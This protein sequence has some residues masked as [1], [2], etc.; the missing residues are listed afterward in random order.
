[1][2]TERQ[3]A[4]LDVMIL[5]AATALTR[6]A[7]RSH[8]L[9]DI[10][11]VNFALALRRF[12]PAVHQPH[13]PGYFLYICL[14]RAL[15]P[16]FRDA[17]TALVAI[18]II[19]SCGAVAMIYVL[20]GNW[21]GRV[22]AVF[23]G[24][25]F[26]FSPLAWF[27]GTVAL[28]YIVEGFFSAL[29]GYLCWR[30]YGGAARSTLPAA[31]V[32]GIAA[33]FRPSS[34]LLLGPLFLF[35]VRKAGLRRAA[36]AMGAL[37]L[38]LLAWFVPMIQM[39]GGS[40]AYVSS[41][42]SLWLAVP[43]KGMLFNSSV[44]NSVARAV[45][46]G[47]IYFLCFGCAAILPM[48]RDRGTTSLNP[49]KTIFTRVWV[50]PGFL[51]FT[52]IYLKFVNSGYLLVLA[53]P[54]CA[55]MGLWASNWYS[56]LRLGDARK[57]WLTA[58][59]AAVNTA[60]FIAAPVYCSYGGVRRFETELRQIIGAVPQ[61]APSGDTMIVGFDSHFLGY[62]HAGYYLP[63]YLTVQFPEVQLTSGK[64]IFAME[65][66]DT[67]LESGLDTTSIRNFILFPLPLGD[68]EYSEYMARVR[69][70][71]PAGALHMVTQ[72]GREYAIGSVA[73]LR[74][75]FPDSVSSA[76]AHVDETR[77]HAQ[78]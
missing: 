13:P 22:P 37:L 31:V 68:K 73:D 36:L 8:Y 40:S 70:R 59:C 34:L 1:M 6:I 21:F 61:I 17:N 19:F 24:A 51:F 20:A 71:F 48:L 52:F 49:G 53:P 41:L 33:G 39:S 18:G 72:G 16:I 69:K 28:T 7:F 38:T 74:F 47:L 60:I 66:R 32:L 78:P 50:A 4:A 15:N 62:R 26:V 10:D 25:I 65:H 57:I 35:S 55:W 3:P 2:T 9:Y 11:S 12:D 43:S 63:G 27:H 5:A 23:A 58:I 56:G 77:L 42:V 29:T 64:R 46:I 54:I 14:G 44:L 76:R 45:F 75:L 30:I 67:W